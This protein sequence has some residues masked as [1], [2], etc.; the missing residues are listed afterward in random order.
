MA[1]PKKILMLG[2]LLVAVLFMT[3]YSP[4]AYGQ[5]CTQSPIPVENGWET[6]PC[7]PNEFQKVFQGNLL[8]MAP[9]RW[10]PMYEYRKADDGKMRPAVVRTVL[11]TLFALVINCPGDTKSPRVIVWGDG[12]VFQN[13]CVGMPTVKVPT[14]SQIGPLPVTSPPSPITRGGRVRQ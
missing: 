11:G 3:A 4:P 2:V 5:V 9:N 13:G 6:R 10:M 1:N 12:R 14:L 7:Y 8:I